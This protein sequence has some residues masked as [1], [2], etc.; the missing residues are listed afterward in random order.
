MR[1]KNMPWDWSLSPKVKQQLL[2]AKPML[3]VEQAERMDSDANCTPSIPFE[4]KQDVTVRLSD[5]ARTSP[6]TVKRM[7]NILFTESSKTMTQTETQWRFDLSQI[8]DNAWRRLGQLVQRT[9][10]NSTPNLLL[11]TIQTAANNTAVADCCDP[12]LLNARV[13]R[14]R[15][16]KPSVVSIELF[17]AAHTA[18]VLEGAFPTGDRQLMDGMK[19]GDIPTWKKCGGMLYTA[20]SMNKRNHQETTVAKRKKLHMS[21]KEKEK[22]ETG[23][24]SRGAI[25]KRV[26]QGK[27]EKKREQN[28]QRLTALAD[29]LGE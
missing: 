18:G 25:K 12:K 15:E 11:P 1:C 16:N 29:A 14:C 22:E 28:R 9:M 4:W 21:Y 3:E 5:K 19:N 17:V 27:L 10:K 6:D 24:V 7:Q 2:L 13:E 20:L 8:S 23:S 26:V